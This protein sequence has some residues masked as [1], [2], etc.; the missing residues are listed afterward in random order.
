MEVVIAYKLRCRHIS[1]IRSLTC[2]FNCT[3]QSTSLVQAEPIESSA[4][5]RMILGMIYSTCRQCHFFIVN[6]DCIAPTSPPF[7]RPTRD[8][9]HRPTDMVS[10]FI[11]EGF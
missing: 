7:H 6:L 10:K 5:V 8:F 4:E 9:F 2:L 3:G 11:C 1:G